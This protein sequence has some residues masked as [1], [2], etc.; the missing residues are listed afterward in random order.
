MWKPKLRRHKVTGGKSE[1]EDAIEKA[2]VLAGVVEARW[3]KIHRVVREVEQ[4]KDENQ[5][6]R[7]IAEAYR[8]RYP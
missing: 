7:R 2:G 5:F 6:G 4:H 3:P 1:A 8:E